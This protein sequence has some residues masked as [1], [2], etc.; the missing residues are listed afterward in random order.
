MP[1]NDARGAVGAWPGAAKPTVGANIVKDSTNNHR[2]LIPG[3][4]L[5]P[6]SRK[7]KQVLLGSALEAVLAAAAEWPPGED[8]P[9]AHSPF[10]LVGFRRSFTGGPSCSFAKP[11]SAAKTR[12]HEEQSAFLIASCLRAFVAAVQKWRE[13]SCVGSYVDGSPSTSPIG[14]NSA[15]RSTASRR[16]ANPS[17]RK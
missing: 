8:S 17:S 12:R 14:A 11:R 16:D 13:R 15:P 2:T 7:M 5:K 1:R 9:H 3:H 10:L 4:L 6:P